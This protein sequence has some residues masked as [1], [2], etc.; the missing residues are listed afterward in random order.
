MTRIAA[1]MTA[2]LRGRTERQPGLAGPTV[3]PPVWNLGST[4]I[5]PFHR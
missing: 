5:A 3:Q 4:Y 1:L 2:L